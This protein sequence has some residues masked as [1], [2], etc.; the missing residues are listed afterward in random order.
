MTGIVKYFNDEKGYGFI[1]YDK[2][3]DDIFVHYTSI[4]GDS[5]KTLVKDEIVDFDL[6]N[7]KNGLRAKNVVPKKTI[8]E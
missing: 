3:K 6:A 4:K 1:I 7:T 5:Y 2:V 8:I